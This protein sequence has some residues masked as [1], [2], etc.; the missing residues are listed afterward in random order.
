MKPIR[1]RSQ[2]H[3]PTKPLREPGSCSSRQGA[4][5]AIR[6]I[7][8]SAP[9]SQGFRGQLTNCVGF[10]GQLTN[11]VNESGRKTWQ[12]SR[13]MSINDS[14]PFFFAR[15]VSSAWGSG[16]GRSAVRPPW[17]RRRTPP[18]PGSPGFRSACRSCR[19]VSWDH[20]RCRVVRPD[21]RQPRTRR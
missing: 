5:A 21:C 4:R 11:C 6:P 16:S 20:G 9:A 8:C 19:Q 12:R 18:K 14:A 15:G 17:H 1:K 3:Y 2:S 7:I 10:R 13:A